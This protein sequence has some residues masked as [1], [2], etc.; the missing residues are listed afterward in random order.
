MGAGPALLRLW[1]PGRLRIG[2]ERAEHYRQAL[3]EGEGGGGG[4]GREG[5][6]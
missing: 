1:R 3:G 5:E 6:R 2:R 4:E